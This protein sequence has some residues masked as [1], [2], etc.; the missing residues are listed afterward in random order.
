MEIALMKEQHK[1]ERLYK[2]RVSR[3]LPFR[4]DKKIPLKPDNNRF[5]SGFFSIC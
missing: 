5:L 4:R 1:A 3:S 2:H